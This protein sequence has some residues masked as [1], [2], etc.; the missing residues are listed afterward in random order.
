MMNVG[1][2]VLPHMRE[3][4]AGTIINVS[5][6]AGVFMLSLISTCCASKFALEGFGEALTYALEP[7][8]IISKI[9]EPGGVLSTRFGTRSSAEGAGQGADASSHV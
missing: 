2:A 6:G 7:L 9:V 8:G 1:R 3:R 4:K 5:S